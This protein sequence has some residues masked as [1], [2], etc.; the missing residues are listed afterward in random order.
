MVAD[1]TFFERGWCCFPYDPSLADWVARTLPAARSAVAAPQ[2][3]SW[4]RYQGTWFAGVNALESN[5]AGA[6]DTGP[7]LTGKAVDFIHETL[8]LKGLAWDRG[9]V[10]VCYPGYPR[11]MSSE[12]D[13]AF[14]YRLNRDAAH[15]DGLRAEGPGRRRH[16][17][18]HH[19]F[20]LGIPMVETSPDASPFVV[21]EGSH[22]CMRA[23]FGALF[24]G[25]APEAWGDIDATEAYKAARREVFASCKRVEVAARPGEAYLVH[26]LALHGFAPW[27]SSATAG[28]DGRM[29]VYF[30]P[31]IGDARRWLNDR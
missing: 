6:V 26:R 4:L 27:G 17:R 23:T 19:G 9:Q 10:S 15:V 25:I 20:I 5:E 1:L 21:W 28:P 7:Q 29:V 30:R 16:V 18:E 11:P 22:E 13:A 24:A 8:G 31:A 14:R 2:N 12:S 3:A